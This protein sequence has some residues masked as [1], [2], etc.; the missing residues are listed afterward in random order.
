MIEERVA[1]ARAEY[2]TAGIDVADVAPDPFAQ[3]ESWFAE[4]DD[5]GVDQPNAF[6]LATATT[7]GRPSARAVL[8]KGFDSNGL[9]FYSSATSRK[10]RELDSNPVAAATFVWTP[11]HRQV[12]FEGGVARVGDEEADRYFASRPRG[13]KVA[14]TI[15]RQSTVVESRET[16]ESAF[17]RLDAATPGDL[18]RPDNWVGWRL[19]PY[20]VE[21]WQGRLNRLHDRLRYRF[22]RGEWILERLSP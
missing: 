8:M 10:G 16:L 17:A 4:V 3:F 11:V 20:L 15:S 9:V 13:A 12:R 1:R 19:T 14:A 21:F 6:V 7:D 22:D 18:S 2:E 5:T